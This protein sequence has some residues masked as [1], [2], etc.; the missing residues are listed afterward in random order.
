MIVE[1]EKKPEIKK[2]KNI[3]EDKNNNDIEI[4]INKEQNEKIKFFEKFWIIEKILINPFMVCKT[5]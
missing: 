1:E 4:F 5:L 2:S 3:K